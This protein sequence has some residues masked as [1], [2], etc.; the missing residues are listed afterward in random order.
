M[1]ASRWKKEMFETTDEQGRI[2]DAYLRYIE[3]EIPQVGPV[4]TFDSARPADVVTAE[5]IACV[6]GVLNG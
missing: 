4:R 2:R 3:M 5:L 6:E 1:R